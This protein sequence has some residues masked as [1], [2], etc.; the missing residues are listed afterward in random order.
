[1]RRALREA[2][3]RIGGPIAEEVEK[4]LT[5]EGSGKPISEALMDMAERCDIDD[6]RS[7]AKQISQSFRY[8]SS[9]AESIK[10]HSEQIRL[11]RR[12]EIMEAANKL[13]IKLIFPVLIF[14]L[15]PTMVVILYPVVVSLMQVLR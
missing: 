8:G 9:L 3:L 2:S 1:M 14:I 15:L 6:F 11:N 12:Y 5:E 10:D 7:L 4:A 13:S